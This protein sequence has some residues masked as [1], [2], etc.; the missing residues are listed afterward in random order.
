MYGTHESFHAVRHI[1]VHESSRVSSR[2]RSVYLEE[3]SGEP[4][5]RPYSST[6]GYAENAGGTDRQDPD[7]LL[8]LLVS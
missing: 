2:E 5:P 4:Q 1:I 8:V 3:G 7:K 6:E